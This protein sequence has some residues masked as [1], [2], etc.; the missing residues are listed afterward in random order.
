MAVASVTAALRKS[1]LVRYLNR[2]SS[3]LPMTTASIK[4]V[5]AMAGRGIERG[6]PG[7]APGGLCRRPRW[8][9][10]SSG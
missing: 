7:A 10:T 6:F 8:K 1:A 2:L 5:A 4:A 9:S 3:E